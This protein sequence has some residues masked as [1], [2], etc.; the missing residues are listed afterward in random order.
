MVGPK[1]VNKRPPTNLNDLN[2]KFCMNKCSKEDWTKM[3]LQWCKRLIKSA[4][5][6]YIQWI[7]WGTVPSWL[8]E[9]LLSVKWNHVRHICSFLIL[10]SKLFC[11][12]GTEANKCSLQSQMHQSSGLW[13]YLSICFVYMS[14][15]FSFLLN[16]VVSGGPKK[17][18]WKLLLEIKIQVL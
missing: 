2:N 12:M 3:S 9:T 5:E 16:L 17:Y 11:C 18:I 13:F 15:S 7:K 8:F 4:D 1:E 14:P 6:G 10:M